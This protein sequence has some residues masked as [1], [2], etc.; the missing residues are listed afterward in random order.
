MGDSS[1][2]LDP[3]LQKA[4]WNLLG[5]FWPTSWRTAISRAQLASSLDPKP[6][7]ASSIVVSGSPVSLR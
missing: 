1:P 4:S 5:L 3:R 2:S 7:W 6:E